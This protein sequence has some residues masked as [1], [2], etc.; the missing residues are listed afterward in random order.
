MYRRAY[1][2]MIKEF[3]L[4]FIKAFLGIVAFFFILIG[5]PVLVALFWGDVAALITFLVT[6]FLI[7]AFFI[8]LLVT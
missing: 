7:S 2:K 3:L 4:N 1:N 5:I 6:A 8:A